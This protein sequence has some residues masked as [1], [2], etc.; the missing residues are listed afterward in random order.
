MRW[1]EKLPSVGFIAIVLTNAALLTFLAWGFRQPA[2]DRVWEL[3][4]EL[5]IGAVGK[6]ASE[7][8]SLIE[9]AMGKYPALA[10][11]LFSQ[12]EAVGLLSQNSQGWLETPDATVLRSSLAGRACAMLLDVKIP[13]HA[14]PLEIEVEGERWRRQLE[15]SRQGSTRLQLPELQAGAEIITLGVL[16]KQSRDEVATL[17]VRVSFECASKTEE[18]QP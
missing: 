5:K 11:A 8:R 18:P 3:H 13:D 17:G 14:L 15:I 7:D 12:G 9:V 1:S 10:S 2:L 16:S 6:L 4:H